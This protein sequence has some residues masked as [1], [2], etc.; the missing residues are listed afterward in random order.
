ME[1]STA[2]GDFGR[3]EGWFPLFDDL[4]RSRPKGHTTV[5]TEYMEFIVPTPRGRG[6]GGHYDLGRRIYMTGIS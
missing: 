2:F 3:K 1:L 4:S 5:R 6:S